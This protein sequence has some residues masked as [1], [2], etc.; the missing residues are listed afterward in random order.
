MEFTAMS[1][2]GPKSKSGKRRAANRQQPVV[3]AAYSVPKFCAAHGISEAF[4]YKLR[5]DGLAPRETRLGKRILI[6]IEAAARWRA[7]RER[8][9]AKKRQAKAAAKQQAEATA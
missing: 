8:A 1:A 6:S 9:S 2:K 3:T 5:E 4:Y 7:E